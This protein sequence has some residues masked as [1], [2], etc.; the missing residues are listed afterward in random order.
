[1]ILY[2]DASALVKHYVAEP[3]STEVNEAISQAEVVSTALISRAEVAAALAKAV[4]TGALTQED[5]M[6]SLQVFRDEWPDLV[7]VQLTE[8]VIARAD[9]FAWEH[10]L[11]AYDAVHLA[12]ASV[13]QDTVGERVTLATFDRHLWTAAQ[14]VGL[15]A[16]PVD[17]PTTLDRW[18]D[19]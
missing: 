8:F 9:A 18:K 17:L 5:A 10:S 13:W 15:A 3:G 2:L 7:R 19:H 12:A 11:R 16:Y 6:H 14:Q 1:M 4:R